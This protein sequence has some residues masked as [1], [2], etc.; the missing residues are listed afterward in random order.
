MTPWGYADEDALE[1]SNGSFGRSPEAITC[2]R[3]PVDLR[4]S[5]G[6]GSECWA[7]TTVCQMKAFPVVDARARS[8]YQERRGGRLGLLCPPRSRRRCGE[9]VRAV[10]FRRDRSRRRARL[11]AVATCAFGRLDVVVNNPAAWCASPCALE[12]S[13]VMVCLRL[14]HRPTSTRTRPLPGAP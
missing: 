4:R 12:R 2:E 11:V 14:L 8:P 13:S 6:R 9:Q 3:M 10:E 1:S 5:I 7:R